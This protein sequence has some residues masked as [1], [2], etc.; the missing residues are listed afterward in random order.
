MYA[1]SAYCGRRGSISAADYI[2]LTSNTPMAENPEIILPGQSV[3]R[4]SSS[5][6]DEHLELLARVLD[7]AFA[8][9]GTN[10][11]FG[12]DAIVGLIPGLGDLVTSAM[13]FLIVFAAWQRGLPRVT[14][15]RMV[16]NIA[17]DTLLGAMPIVGDLFDLAWKS[18]KKNMA[19]LKRATADTGAKNQAK[20][21]VALLFLVVA[22]IAMIAIPVWV[23]VWLLQHAF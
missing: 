9:P 7:D 6:D 14:V 15:A 12:L 20:D 19:L 1:T 17:V 4:R 21:W 10:I 23:L 13:S 3:Q 8:V 5:L 11:R 18:N 2:P 16:G 22:A